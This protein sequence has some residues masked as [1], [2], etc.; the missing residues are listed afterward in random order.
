MLKTI[1]GCYFAF[2][3]A[4]GISAVMLMFVLEPKMII[5]SLIGVTVLSLI[6]YIFYRVVSKKS[7]AQQKYIAIRNGR[8]AQV[9][10]VVLIAVF[11]IAAA[12][13]NNTSVIHFI[14]V[15]FGF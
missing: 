5:P 14:R 15:W 7:E 8:V 12:K 2:I 3:A 9:L 1:A 13:H 4:L 10:A 11:F 6:I